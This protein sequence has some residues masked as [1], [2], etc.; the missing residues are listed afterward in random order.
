MNLERKIPGFTHAGV[1]TEDGR[2]YAGE[3]VEAVIAGATFLLVT[4]PSG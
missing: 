3:V 4:V 2:T 1:D